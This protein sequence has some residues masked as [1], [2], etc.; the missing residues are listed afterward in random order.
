[1]T[2][3]DEDA[4]S[5][6]QTGDSRGI[7]VPEEELEEL[8]RK[9]Q[10]YDQYVE[11]FGEN[12]QEIQRKMKLLDK[13]TRA[14][15]GH[16]DDSV[17]GVPEVNKGDLECKVCHK[18]FK[19]TNRLK[20][21]VNR[22]HK[23]VT[24]YKCDKCKPVRYLSDLRSLRTHDRNAHADTRAKL[25]KRNKRR[26]FCVENG[27]DKSFATNQARKVHVE[28]AHMPPQVHKCA[29]CSKEFTMFRYVQ[30]HL[31]ICQENPHATLSHQKCNYCDKKFVGKYLYKHMRKEHDWGSM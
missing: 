17:P 25:V 5:Q 4:G 6:Q 3:S 18:K 19:N 9:A 30:E 7:N 23:G 22:W 8:K 26:F 20:A 11:V 1:V 15:G 2:G 29:H 28:R 31:K 24:E 21:H 13:F 12:L 27:C 16:D 10:I 14:L